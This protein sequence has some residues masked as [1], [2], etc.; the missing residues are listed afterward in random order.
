MLLQRLG[1]LLFSIWYERIAYKG[2]GGPYTT[3]T[4]HALAQR[5]P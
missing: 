3:G 5:E 2:R 1:P 4:I